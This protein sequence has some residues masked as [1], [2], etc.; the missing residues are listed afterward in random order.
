MVS[1]K[2]TSKLQE[3][4]KGVKSDNEDNDKDGE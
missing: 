3:Q 2:Y 4:F 1:T